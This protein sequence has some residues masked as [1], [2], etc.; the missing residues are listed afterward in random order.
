MI[1]WIIFIAVYILIDIY[2]FQAIKTLTKNNWIYGVY[3]F[4]SLIVLFTLIYQLGFS[5]TPKIMAPG[6]MY[7][8]GFFLA[9]LVPKLI[10]VIFM[11][12]EDIIR[13]IAGLFQKQV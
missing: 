5:G 3:I 12:G 10:L 6:G 11:F 7:I 8:F 2:S 4:I 1:R 13:L 9:F